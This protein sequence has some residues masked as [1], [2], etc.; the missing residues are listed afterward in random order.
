MNI[1]CATE[2]SGSRSMPVEQGTNRQPPSTCS[3]YPHQAF[4]AVPCNTAYT[5]LARHEAREL[6][7]HY[8]LCRSCNSAVT[9]IH[10]GACSKACE[11][12][13]ICERT[14]DHSCNSRSSMAHCSTCL[15]WHYISVYLVAADGP[16]KPPNLSGSSF[17]A[18]TALQHATCSHQ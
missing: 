11:I 1:V 15:L 13:L 12:M 2:A 17:C 14:K 3:L 7:L 9:T 8:L 4:P 6:P 10:W 5:Q 18:M 16:S